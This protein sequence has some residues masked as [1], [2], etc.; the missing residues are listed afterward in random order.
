MPV[1]EADDVRDALR[2][3]PNTHPDVRCSDNVYNRMIY[4][5]NGTRT[6]KYFIGEESNLKVLKYIY[7]CNI[8]DLEKDCNVLFKSFQ[9]HVDMELKQSLDKSDPGL[10]N[11][12][13]YC[14]NISLKSE[15][16]STLGAQYTYSV[17]PDNYVTIADNLFT[18][19]S[20]WQKVPET[21]LETRQFMVKYANDHI[22]SKA[23]MT[24]F[25]FCDV[26]AWRYSKAKVCICRFTM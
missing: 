8:P 13:D 9:T 20:T 15:F 5:P 1:L 18:G 26:V 25:L 21:L 4:W 10:F 19:I 24:D 11:Y 12:F 22:R 2:C 23:P 7:T 6:F 16:P 17:I 3:S 14:K